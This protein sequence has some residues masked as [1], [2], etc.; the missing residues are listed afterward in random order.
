MNADSA[1]DPADLF[2]HV[3]AA[4][5]AALRGQQ[6]ELAWELAAEAGDGEETR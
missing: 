6:R 4:S 2:E 3:Y 1:P 5:T